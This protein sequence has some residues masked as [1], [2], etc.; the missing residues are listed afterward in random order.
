MRSCCPKLP[1]ALQRT[2]TTA[3]VFVHAKGA[4]DVMLDCAGTIGGWKRIGSGTYEVARVVIGKGNTCKNGAHQATSAGK[5]GITVRGWSFA[6]SY[7]Y[8]AGGNSV[9]VNNVVVPPMPR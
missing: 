9:P 1:R 4:G 5:F 3:L 6:A 7:R 8:R 2:K